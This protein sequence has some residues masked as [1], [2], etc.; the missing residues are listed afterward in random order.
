MVVESERVQVADRV[1]IEPE[2]CQ[3]ARVAGAPAR[4]GVGCRYQLPDRAGSVPGDRRRAELGRGRAGGRGLPVGARCLCRGA[5]A[6][7]QV[8]AVAAAEWLDDD[9]RA[10][11]GQGRR[12]LVRR[13]RDD[14]GRDRD[15]GPGQQLLGQLLVSGNIDSDG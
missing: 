11:L 14:S 8:R 2:Q 13:P 3:L 4:I 5:H 12:G 9:R 7:R 15:A 10:E 1:G 6:D